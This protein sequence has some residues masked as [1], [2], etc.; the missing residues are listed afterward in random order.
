MT[1]SICFDEQ[2]D[3][4]NLNKGTTVYTNDAALLMILKEQK[5]KRRC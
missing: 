2:L 5:Q 1:A 4:C 3:V